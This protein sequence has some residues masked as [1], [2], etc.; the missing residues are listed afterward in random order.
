[1][2]VSDAFCHSKYAQKPQNWYLANGKV[3]RLDF[4]SNIK[5]FEAAVRNVTYLFQRAD[6]ASNKPLRRVHEVEFGNVKL[7]PTNEQRLLNYRLFF[8]EDVQAQKFTNST[9]ELDE[10]CYIS[11][12]MVVHADE[13][14]AKG[15]FELSDL[16]A[17][18]PDKLHTKPFVEGKHL[19]R[20]LPS[21]KKW[22]E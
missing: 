3:L 2:I 6:G 16:V 4:F 11:V 8:P 1:M 21:T 14:V 22:L 20:W 13:K 9:L 12:G 10:I 7:L 17:E 18:Y 19:A 5:I 15:E